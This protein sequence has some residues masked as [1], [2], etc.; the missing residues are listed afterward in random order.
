MKRQILPI[1]ALLLA[2]VIAFTMAA[3]GKPAAEIDAQALVRTLLQKVPYDTELLPGEGAAEAF[4]SGL[5]ENAKAT[6]YAG[7]GYCPDELVLLELAGEKD[8]DAAMQAVKRHLDELRSQFLNYFPEEVPKIDSAVTRQLGKYI[9]VCITPDAETAEDI[10]DHAGDADYLNA[11][12]AAPVQN[13]SAETGTPVQPEPAPQV[14]GTEETPTENIPEQ[15]PEQ[16][17]QIPEQPEGYPELHSQSGTYHDYGT[18]VIRVDDRAY[19]QYTFVPS[20]AEQ[21]TALVNRAAEALKGVTNVYALPIPTAIGIVL[22]DDIAAQLG[23]T[24][25]QES[26][27]ER[28]LAGMNENVTGVNCYNDLMRH[29]DEY[30]YFHTDYHWNGRGA[31]YAYEAFCRAK[32]IEPYTLDQRTE[33]KFDGFLGALYWNGSG[34]DPALKASADTVEAFLPHSPTATMQFTDQNGQTLPWNIISDVSGWKASTKYSTFAG[35]DNPIAVFT[36]PEVTDGS[37]CVVI[38]ESYG[39]ALLPYLVDHY[40]TIYEIDYRY[41][42]GNIPAFAA[43][44]HANDLIFANNL[45]MIRS[46]YLLGQLA[47]DL[48]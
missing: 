31:Y 13:P 15:V 36:N 17:E 21:Y 23:N 47:E 11:L 30:L 8:G 24:V 35:A 27:I 3:C 28:I 46:N 22:P 6:R 12:P 2:A 18:G 48:S 14:P 9:F 44:K 41:W 45:G 39:N 37:V 19:E 1:I 38:K 32:G 25:D 43:E 4:F 42:S 40:S 10:L 34:E 5:P 20:A 7:S 33:K 16:P 29:R 26:D